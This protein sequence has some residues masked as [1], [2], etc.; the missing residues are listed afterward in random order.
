MSARG[1]LRA[2]A[3]VLALGGAIAL[4]GCAG[5][6][7]LDNP[8]TPPVS[9]TPT[10]EQLVQPTIEPE[11]ESEAP[12][13]AVGA[14]LTRDELIAQ[15]DSE[16]RCSG[17]RTGVTGSNGSVVRVTGTCPDIEVTSDGITVVADRVGGVTMKASG[18][19]VFV[20]RADAV[21]INGDGNV[22]LW[23]SGKPKVTD[24]G[25]ENTAGSED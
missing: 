15:A 9:A 10:T 8:E 16:V 21:T 12:S 13:G 14:V 4:A 24:R 7:F 20:T 11:Q 19:V 17:E 22:V 25:S 2:A 23:S 6:Q 1:P 5:G 18:S 3:V